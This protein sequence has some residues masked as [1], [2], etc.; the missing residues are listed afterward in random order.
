MI[1]CPHACPKEWSLNSLNCLLRLA[2]PPHQPSGSCP[3]SGYFTPVPTLSSSHC[4][5]N[6]ISEFNTPFF[7][8][9]FCDKWFSTLRGHFNTMWSYHLTLTQ[10]RVTT[11]ATMSYLQSLY[12]WARTGVIIIVRGWQPECHSVY[13]H[14]IC[15][16][17]NDPKKENDTCKYL[18]PIRLN[19]SHMFPGFFLF[20]CLF[21]FN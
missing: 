20:Y 19:A 6:D 5:H 4:F 18:F 15:K 2:H 12:W 8:G 11:S 3:T 9:H 14:W 21:V 7:T 16:W 13:A 10:F 17:T 1:G